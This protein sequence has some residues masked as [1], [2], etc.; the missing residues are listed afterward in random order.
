MDNLIRINDRTVWFKHVHNPATRARLEQ[1]GE[2]E[3]IFLSVDGV[4]GR[5]RRMKQGRN[6]HPTPGIKPDANM[7]AVWNEWFKNRRGEA[8]ELHEVTLADD[9]LAATSALFSEWNSPEDEE[10]FRDL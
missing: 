6:P 4:V 7:K 9:Y 5:W 8:V 10:A 2:D 3:A 1:L